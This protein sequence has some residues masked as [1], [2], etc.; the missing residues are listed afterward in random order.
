M[1]VFADFAKSKSMMQD[2]DLLRLAQY[3]SQ[4]SLRLTEPVRIDKQTNSRS[5]RRIRS[6][7]RLHAITLIQNLFQK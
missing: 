1:C 6:S 3:E 5:I 4:E 7:S 2:I